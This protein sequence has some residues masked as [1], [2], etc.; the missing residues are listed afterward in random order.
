MIRELGPDDAPLAL[1]TMR[2]LR[3][4]LADD[5]D[6]FADLLNRHYWPAG[7]RLVAVFEDGVTDAVAVAGFREGHKL[8][9]GHH[10]YVDDLVT[11][12]AHRGRGHARALLTWIDDEAAR[13][14]CDS[15]H[16]DS[17]TP[18]KP[19]HRLY[20]R[21]GYDITSFHFARRLTTT[22]ESPATGH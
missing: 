5:V 3:P 19:A 13:L 18:R 8:A 7:Y 9:W 16:L 21:H 1:S 22:H 11:A 4:H 17:G 6:A 12:E 2:E 14:G 10:L 15:V 20:L